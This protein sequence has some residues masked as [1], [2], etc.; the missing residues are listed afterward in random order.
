MKKK[1]V[2]PVR[3]KII[4]PRLHEEITE[5]QTKKLRDIYLNIGRA[6][7]RNT[8]EQFERGFLFVSDIDRDIRWWMALSGVFQ[9]CLRRFPN[10][11]GDALAVETVFISLCGGADETKVP[12]KAIRYLKANV[13]CRSSFMQPTH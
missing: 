2:K 3:I 6:F 13:P 9:R 12:A 5:E 7:Y 4:H 10:V 1:R 11:D 8:F